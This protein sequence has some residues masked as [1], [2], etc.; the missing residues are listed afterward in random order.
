VSGV[1]KLYEQ[2]TD[3]RSRSDALVLWQKERY[4]VYGEGF[5]GVAG[6]RPHQASALGWK[7][8]QRHSVQ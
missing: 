6:T 7:L 3:D 5:G 4:L 8:E 1:Q 2:Q